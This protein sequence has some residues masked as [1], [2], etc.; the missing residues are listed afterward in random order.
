MDRYGVDSITAVEEIP[1]ANFPNGL[2]SKYSIHPVFTSMAMSRISWAKGKGG[3]FYRATYLYEGFL[4][5]LPDPVYE[6]SGSLGEEPIQLHKDFISTLAGTPATPLNG[7]IFLD[8]D[9]QKITTDDSRG[10]FREFFSTIS[11]VTNPKAGIE[12][13]L[14]PGAIWTETSFSTTRPTDLGSLGEIDEPTGPE[15]SFGAGRNWL[16]F[17]VN[18]QQRG[19]I[20][21]TRKTWKLSG[22]AGFDTDI[23]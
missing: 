8:P 18:Y 20:F 2:R 19:F 3:Q 12:A 21:A 13:Y 23:Y 7:A 5:S 9:T 10:V 14:S 17:D 6:L 22:R 4:Q 16:Y 1:I 11:G 15:P